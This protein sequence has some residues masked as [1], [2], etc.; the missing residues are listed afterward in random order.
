M[1]IQKVLES[2]D[3]VR[4]HA[5]PG[6]DKQKNSEH[7]WGVALIVSNIYPSCSK[8][9]LL[10]AMTHDCA[11]IVTGDIPFTVKKGHPELKQVLS[12]IEFIHNT[13]MGIV[14]NLNDFEESV[15]KM[16]DTLEC[17]NFCVDQIDMGHS[18]AWIPYNRLKSLFSEN[19]NGILLDADILFESIERKALSVDN[20]Y[21]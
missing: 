8:E 17:M 14:F 18:K 1:N 6:V 20:N 5:T 12:N 11:E 4:F 3:V 19:F 21:R 16:A 10:A 9:L 2:G 7:Q 15:L 13:G